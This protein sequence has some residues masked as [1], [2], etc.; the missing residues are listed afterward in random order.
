MNQPAKEIHIQPPQAGLGT[1]FSSDTSEAST[2]QLNLLD[3]QVKET[4]DKRQFRKISFYGLCVIICLLLCGLGVWMFLPNATP[5]ANAAWIT[6]AV[7]LATVPTLL[8]LAVLRLVFGKEKA[9][10][11]DGGKESNATLSQALVK[12][13]SN[14]IKIYIKP[15]N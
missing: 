14:L 10:K 8:S 2:Y 1:D 7:I 5:H 11:E 4:R 6:G 13:I 3:E 9:D 15:H 12:E